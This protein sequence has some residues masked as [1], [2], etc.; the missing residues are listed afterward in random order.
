MSSIRRWPVIRQIIIW[1][2]KYSFPG[3]S[4]VPI[5]NVITFIY[6]EA[7]RDDIV[8]RANS[9]AFSFFLAIFPAIIF[10]FTLL[11]HLPIT[12]DYLTLIK[13]STRELIPS[14]AHKYL[15]NIIESVVSI[16]RSGL[17]SAG[18]ILAIIFSSSGMMSL[19]YGF[20]KSYDAV[21]KKRTYVRNRFV[22]TTL[23]MLLLS[24]FMTSMLLII[25][26][27]PVVQL[28]INK[29]SLGSYSEFV[30]TVLRWVLVVGILYIGIT[31]IYRY[32]S[33]MKERITW[34]NPGAILATI[35]SVISSLVFSFFIDNFGRYN[36][37]YG[38]IGALLVLMIWLEINAFII[39]VGFEMN[40]GIAV[41]K[42]WTKPLRQ[43]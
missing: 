4:G 7:M 6:K 29:L 12:A 2:K 37:I 43:Q 31:L 22:A 18:F 39:L 36:E 8:T 24:L 32:G 40:A 30:Y 19:M 34:V 5:Y 23:T 41:H 21:F 11:P 14:E 26:G 33:A 9:V 3:F 1:S 15:F 25:F 17:L 28:V 20:E 27:E 38:S 35:L 16:R 42:A 10:L 13:E